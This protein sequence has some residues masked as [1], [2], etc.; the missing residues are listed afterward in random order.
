MA[1]FVEEQAS[2]YLPFE[3]IRAMS[4]GVDCRDVDEKCLL[5]FV[6]FVLFE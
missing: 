1:W 3:R 5:L 2:L 4:L 6:L